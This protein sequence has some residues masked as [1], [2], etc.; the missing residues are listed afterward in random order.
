MYLD[1]WFDEKTLVVIIEGNLYSPQTLSMISFVFIIKKNEYGMIEKD[2]F[3]KV[4]DYKLATIED[5]SIQ[6][7]KNS[8]DEND[9]DNEATKTNYF[10]AILL[11]VI[12]RIST[13][14]FQR[15]SE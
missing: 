7:N 5:N 4:S 13:S 6:K 1:D 11:F 15:C 3:I 12:V 10:F 9:I 14:D 2:I 8:L